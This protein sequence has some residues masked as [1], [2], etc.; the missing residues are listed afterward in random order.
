VAKLFSIVSPDVALFGQK[1]Y[2][3]G[4]V[5]WKMVRDL[6]FPVRIVVVPTVREAD[7]L[8]ISSRN[9][10]LSAEG[11]AIASMIH[12]SLRLARDLFRKGDR[13]PDRLRKE[14]VK[15]L[16]GAKS[17]EVEYIGFCDPEYLEPVDRAVSGTVVMIAVRIEGIRL[18]DNLRI[19]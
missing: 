7:G 5:I 18:I 3:Q 16:S 9:V 15:F 4:V 2:Q 11:R 13:D 10:R 14:V 8:A 17:I 1:D 6:H 12:R 19:S